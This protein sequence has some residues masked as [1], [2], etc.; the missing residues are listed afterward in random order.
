MMKVAVSVDGKKVSAHFGRCEKYVIFEENN[1]KEVA[2]KE[3]PN[4]GHEPFF[5]PKF[6]SEKGVKRI[7]TCGIGPRAAGLFGELGIEVVAGVDGDVDKVI[8]KYLSGEL[9]GGAPVCQHT[10]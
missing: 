1:G 3:V 6:L 9:K 4:P 5:L 7:I 2:R 10:H 8:S